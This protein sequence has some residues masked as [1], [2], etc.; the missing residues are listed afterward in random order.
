MK[1]NISAMQ[2]NT[3]VGNSDWVGGGGGDR[4]CHGTSTLFRGF[5]DP[6]SKNVSQSFRFSHRG[7]CLL[8]LSPNT[9]YLLT[10]SFS[11]PAVAHLVTGKEMSFLSVRFLTVQ[12]KETQ[13][14]EDR[15]DVRCVALMGSTF[16]Q[17][18]TDRRHIILAQHKL[19]TRG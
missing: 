12:S 6:S 2:Q 13:E 19:A 1:A 7:C 9:A 11:F 15:F 18:I 4:N 17:E 3:I 5:S 10:F 8:I 16:I 14:G